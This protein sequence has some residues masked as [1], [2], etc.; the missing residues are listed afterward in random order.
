ML[1]SV[2]ERTREIGIRRAVGA[3]RKDI[4]LHFVTESVCIS[5]FGGLL[6]MLMGWA[7]VR[8]IALYT[9]WRVLIAPVFVLLALCVSGAV[10]LT[11]GIFPA[12]QAAR[13]DPAEAVRR[14]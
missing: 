6:G 7:L 10:G 5:A 1:A 12:W 3:T 13:I 8:G 9:G 2:S 11:F 4:L 14:E